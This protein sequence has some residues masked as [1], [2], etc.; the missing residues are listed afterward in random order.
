M[1]L[2][3]L[4]AKILFREFVALDHR[5]HGAIEN[6]DFFARQPV[7]RFENFRAVGF[8]ESH[9]VASRGPGARPANGICRNKIGAVVGVEMKFVHARFHEVHDLFGRGG[10]RDQ[11]MG[12]R[13]VFQAL[14]AVGEPLRHTGAG[15]GGEAATCLKLRTG[16]MPGTIGIFDAFRASALKKAQIDVV[17]EEELGNGARGAGV[18]LRFSASMSL[19]I[20]AL[21]DGLG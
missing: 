2:E 4:A 20:E 9:A 11:R 13:I 21:S 6:Q 5:A 17:V 12:F 8:V 16:M 10:R 7:E 1:A 19:S 14:E 18:Y 3:A 15:L